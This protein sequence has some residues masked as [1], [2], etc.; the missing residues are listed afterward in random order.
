MELPHP[1]SRLLIRF[2]LTGHCA[3]PS[4]SGVEIDGGKGGAESVG[5]VWDVLVLD[6]SFTKLGMLMLGMTPLRNNGFLKMHEMQ[7][8]LSSESTVS[9]QE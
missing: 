3:P 2:L 7:P 5:V 4:F 1:I 6:F 8:W 9:P